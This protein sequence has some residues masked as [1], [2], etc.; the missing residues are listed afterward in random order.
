[1]RVLCSLLSHS[2][3]TSPLT[4]ISLTA[5]VS[6]HPRLWPL[7]WS[8]ALIHRDSTEFSACTEPWLCW[9][10]WIGQLEKIVRL[11]HYST[12][13][14]STVLRKNAQILAQ[15]IW[16]SYIWWHLRNAM[17]FSEGTR[18]TDVVSLATTYCALKLSSFHQPNLTCFERVVPSLWVYCSLPIVRIACT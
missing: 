6:R 7:L 2:L 1:M 4:G 18:G 15:R 13:L 5:D 12:R 17:Q 14:R 8:T 16:M 9:T 11:F 10:L 3:F